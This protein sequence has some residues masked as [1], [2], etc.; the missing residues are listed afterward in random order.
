[1]PIIVNAIGL[2]VSVHAFKV[3]G[4]ILNVSKVGL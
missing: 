2:I 1:M 3:P 4:A